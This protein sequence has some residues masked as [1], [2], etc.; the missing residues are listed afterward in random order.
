MDRRE[1]YNH[2][3]VEARALFENQMAEVW[4]ALPA[5]VISF[6]AVAMTVVLQAAIQAKVLT[7]LNA[8][9][10]TDVTITNLVDVPVQFPSGGG[11]AL[12]FPLAAGDEGIVVFSCR[13][14]DKWWASGG[15]Q[16]QA[17]MRMHDIADGM[18]IPGLRSQPRVITGVSTNSTQLRSDD[19]Q[20]YV[21]LAAGHVVN[22]VTPGGLNITG[23]VKIT[24]A[25]DITGNLGA[26]GNIT[27]G[28]GTADQIG[29]RT[30]KHTGVTT[31]GG[32]TAVPT[33][34]T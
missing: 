19:G 10:Y 15:V 26:T 32:S 17:E 8:Q 22:V 24:G 23:G 4:T 3:L 16:P 34:G 13:C 12:T 27:G 9:S 2:P 31:G 25:V 1:R 33:P 5:I 28:V 14:I 29:L 18:F 20:V 21:E 11:Y 30:H 7:S 6:D